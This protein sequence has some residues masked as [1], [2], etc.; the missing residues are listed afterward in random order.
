MPPHST[1]GRPRRRLPVLA[2][3]VACLAFTP[4][5]LA[6]SPGVASA[7]APDNVAQPVNF[8]DADRKSVV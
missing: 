6:L 2:A 4:A 8:G 7:A 3:L 5:L 1:T